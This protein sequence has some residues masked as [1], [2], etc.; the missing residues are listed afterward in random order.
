[1]PSSSDLQS[2]DPE[3]R[4]RAMQALASRVKT[5]ASCHAE[6][7]PIF[8]AT[9]LHE[10]DP[11]TVLSAARGLETILGPER[12]YT[13]WV[14]LLNHPNSKIVSQV[15]LALTHRRY[16]LPL[17]DVLQHRS[18]LSVRQSTIRALGRL[19]DPAIFPA[20]LPFLAHPELRPHTIEA[21][22]ELGDVRA[23]PHLEALANDPTEAWPEDNHGPML[24]VG[25]LACRAL[26]RFDVPATP[27]PP[28]PNPRAYLPLLAAVV[29]LGVTPILMPT[30]LLSRGPGPWFRNHQLLTLLF[31]LPALVGLLYGVFVYGP[32]SGI[33]TMMEKFGLA[34]GCALCAYFVLLYTHFLFS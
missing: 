13:S 20:L 25:D 16:A 23:Y 9:I 10:T 8:H 28:E 22:G 18:E 1:M 29:Q 15:V 6:A 33:L 3:S 27:S 14:S 17:I 7:L 12:A 30:V 2:P 11:W 5:D 32:R 21:L 26:A 34:V 4:G 24:R 19:R 31:M